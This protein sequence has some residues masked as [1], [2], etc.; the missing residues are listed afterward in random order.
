MRVQSAPFAKHLDCS[1][2]K[3]RRICGLALTILLSLIPLS[4][5]AKPPKVAPPPTPAKP[6]YNTALGWILQ[7]SRDFGGWTKPNDGRVESFWSQELSSDSHCKIRLSEKVDVFHVNNTRIKIIR[8]CIFSFEDANIH[9]FALSTP[10]NSDTPNG[11]RVYFLSPIK[12]KETMK[13]NEGAEEDDP[14]PVSPSNNWTLFF[15]QKGLPERAM[16]A[17]RD[18]ATACGA[19]T[20]P[21]PY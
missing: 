9:Q 6:D 20:S 14:Y 10:K 3:M 7:K 18:L 12:C 1:P 5:L 2:T 13:T 19:S 8:S 4:V 17:L 15:A 11:V 16:T 21:E